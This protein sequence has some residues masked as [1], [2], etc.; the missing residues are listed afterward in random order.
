MPRIP[1]TFREPYPTAATELQPSAAP[2]CYYRT[3]TVQLP[4]GTRQR[5]PSPFCMVACTRD[6][7]NTALRSYPQSHPSAGTV[8]QTGPPRPSI[9]SLPHSTPHCVGYS[10]VPKSGEHVTEGFP[11]PRRS[12]REKVCRCRRFG[13]TCCLY[14]QGCSVQTY[15]LYRPT[16]RNMHRHNTTP[17]GH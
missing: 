8:P 4:Y 10:T 1:T 15:T 17:T 3:H 16:H 13:R 9:R 14:H 7:Y 2:P 12:H 5:R 6:S 11:V